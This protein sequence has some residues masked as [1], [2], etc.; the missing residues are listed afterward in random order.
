MIHVHCRYVYNN[1]TVAS[2]AATPKW[3]LALGGAGLVIGLATYG[4]NI[5]KVLGVQMA[6]MTPSRGFSAELATALMVSLA[7]MY[8]LPVST[9]Q[10]IVGAEVGVGLT[11]SLK[12]TG[13]NWRLFIKTFLGWVIAFISTALI[14][15][16]MFSQGVFAPSINDLSAVSSLNNA[17]VNVMRVQLNEL[18]ATNLANNATLEI[19]DPKLSAQVANYNKNITSMMNNKKNGECYGCNRTHTAASVRTDGNHGWS[20]L[21][22]AFVCRLCFALLPM[23][24]MLCLLPPA[25][26]GKTSYMDVMAVFKNVTVLY[27][28]QTTPIVGFHGAPTN[29]SQ[30]IT[31]PREL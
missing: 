9:T 15:A 19:W 18:E 23:L 22:A 25:P 28:E 24:K 2:S 4:Y 5:M 7:S 8:G 11:E 12:G 21:H 31:V 14:S 27:M 1:Y 17:I 30:A 29:N 20:K 10:C 16:A 3:C 13:F 6:T 26:A